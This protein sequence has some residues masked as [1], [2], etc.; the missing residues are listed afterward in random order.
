MSICL[1][2]NDVKDPEKW[3]KKCQVCVCGGGGV[4][5]VCMCARVCVCVCICARMCVPRVEK[6]DTS[7]FIVKIKPLANCFFF[8]EHIFV[9]SYNFKCSEFLFTNIT[10]IMQARYINRPRQL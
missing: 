3:L 5:R 8:I 1:Y 9:I 10:T 4:V 7:F 6:N 2:V